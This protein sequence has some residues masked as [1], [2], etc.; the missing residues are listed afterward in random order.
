[1]GGAQGGIGYVNAPLTSSEVRGFK[2][3]MKN[4]LTDP[5]GL[6]EQFD[7]VLGPKIYTWGEL[8]S[9][10]KS[11][12]TQE[13][14][15][16]IRTAG[17]QIW[18]RE[19][20][21]GPARECKMPIE[22]LN[23]NPNDERGRRDTNDYRT[24]II[25]GIREAAPCGNNIRKAFC[26]MQGKQETPMDWLERLRQDIRLYSG[27]DPDS[28]TG[29]TLLK[30]HFV[31][32]AWPDIRK[33]LEKLENW[34]RRDLEELLREAQKVYVRRDEERMK[35]KAKVMMARDHQSQRRIPDERRKG[36][37][38]RVGGHRKGD[39]SEV[40]YYCKKA[41]HFKSNCPRWIKDRRTF[42][43]VHLEGPED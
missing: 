6:S 43:E 36:G 21:Q 23:W 26:G 33:K 15:Q 13:E 14:R 32:N 24:L 30:V 17:I 31:T 16:M 4:L 7:Q 8:D 35:T 42:Q 1:M 20:Q 18:D 29:E 22:P 41:G 10:L 25:K 27:I 5:V 19:N 40:C 12:F 3:E 11:L 34:Q 28:G 2:K 39:D 38:G 9:I 37:G